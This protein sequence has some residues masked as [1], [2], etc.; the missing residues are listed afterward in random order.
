[1]LKGG[2][3]AYQVS[4][5]RQMIAFIE[6]L[7]LA[8]DQLILCY[9]HPPMTDVHFMHYLL[10]LN[11]FVLQCWDSRDGQIVGMADFDKRLSETDA[12][13][14]ILIEQLAVSSQQCSNL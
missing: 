1:M 13:L 4:Q 6:F 9:L 3:S 5:L 14:Q 7:P 10:Y 8:S 11:A 2:T 12:Y